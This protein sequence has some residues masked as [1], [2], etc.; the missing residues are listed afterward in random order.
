[1]TLSITEIAALPDPVLRNLWITQCYH[2]LAVQLRD[3]GLAEDATWCAFAVWASKTAGATIR[4]QELPERVQ[5]LLANDDQATGALSRFN[6]GLGS[7]LERSIEHTH[8]LHIVEEVSAQVSA[9]IAEGNRLVFAEL[10][11]LFSALLTDWTGGTDAARSN[12]A[13]ELA[14]SIKLLHDQGVDTT[15]VSAAFAAYQQALGDQGQRP[16]LVL[17]A[18]ILAVSHEQ[19]RLQ[20][21]IADAL[22]AAI[23]DVFDTVMQRDVTPH[24]PHADAHRLFDRVAGDIG[25]ALERVWQSALT[26]LMLRLITPAQTFDLHRN[27]PPLPDGL[28]PHE[29]ADL[30]GTAAEA[31]FRQWDRAHGTGDP[32][33]ADDWAV[34]PERMNYIAT[35][36]RSRQRHE[37]LF[38]PP[39]SETQLA[40]LADGRLPEGPL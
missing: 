20:P 8:L 35:L 15:N 22:N 1:V 38:R 17:A 31:P 12:A 19:E 3:A 29:L 34:L 26:E 2:E 11:P 40:A 28:F 16:T 10:A 14:A 30:T 4:G 18:N 39:F 23:S 25:T 27:V 32:T 6:H 7:W 13:S 21:N 33:G 37:V 9:S 24:L 36:F 5:E